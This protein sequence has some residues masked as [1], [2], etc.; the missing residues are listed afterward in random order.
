[1]GAVFEVYWL[2]S[3]VRHLGGSGD[4]HSASGLTVNKTTTTTSITTTITKCYNYNN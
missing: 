2:Q 4:E 1:V 3:R